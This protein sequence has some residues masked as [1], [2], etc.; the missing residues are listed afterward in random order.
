VANDLCT[1]DLQH[2][3]WAS[4]RIPV[5]LAPSN[6]TNAMFDAIDTFLTKMKEV[7]QRF[8]M[9]PHNLSQYRTLD[10]LPHAIEEPEDLPMEM[11]DW[12]TYFP[13]AKP[14]RY[15]RGDVYT[16][17]LIRSSIP[18]GK[19]MKENNDWLRKT[20]YGLWEATI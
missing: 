2:I 6:A 19:I 3:F 11:D 5:L 16:T 14:R 15:N 12:L 13:Q 8:T 1:P 18:L 20:R 7:D 4:I 9:F 10:N 17:A